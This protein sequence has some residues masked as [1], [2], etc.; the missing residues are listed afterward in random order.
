MSVMQSGLW[1]N[2]QPIPF[3]HPMKYPKWMHNCLE[4]KA[5]VFGT[6]IK[7]DQMEILAP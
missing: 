5:I 4:D 1:K 2:L 6:Y 7:G 3:S